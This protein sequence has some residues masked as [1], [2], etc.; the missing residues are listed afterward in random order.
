MNLYKRDNSRFWQYEFT[1][2]GERYRGTTRRSDKDAAQRVVALEYERIMNAGQF[3]TKPETTLEECLNR[4]IKTQTTPT[5]RVAYEN[6]RNR[7]LGKGKFNRVGH[8]SLSPTMKLSDLRQHHI[9]DLRDARMSEGGAANSVS[10]ELRF[11]KSAYNASRRRF[12]CSPD[13]T[14]TLPKKFEK[15]RRITREEE[16]AIMH[17]LTTHAGTAGY[18]KSLDLFVF[19]IESGVRLGEAL[20]ITWAD[21]DLDEKLMT[22]WNKKT[23]KETLVP[24]SDRLAENLRKRHNQPQPFMHMRYAVLQ[25]R[26]IMDDI[27]NGNERVNATKGRATLH[28]LRDTYAMRLDEAG[29]S[30][31]QIRDLLGHSSIATTAKYA[32]GEKRNAAEAARRALNG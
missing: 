22:V 24:I 5:T 26:G 3:G 9:D 1:I 28:T 23:G 12:A 31:L 18:D 19:L 7:I 14:F 17:V 11:F 32:R 15:S 27:C 16:R 4:V 10:L 13:L 6:C 25:L 20:G 30:L 29:V 2:R 21:I 8:F